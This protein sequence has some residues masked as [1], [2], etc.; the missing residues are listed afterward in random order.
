V[1][2]QELT[3]IIEEELAQA[4]GTLSWFGRPLSECLQEPAERQFLNSH[5]NDAPE[6]L[7]LVFEEGPKPGEG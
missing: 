4:G 3:R 5:N 1:T 2:A 7:W 6:D